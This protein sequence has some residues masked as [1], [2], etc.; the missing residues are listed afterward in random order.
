VNNHLT[1]F[2][3]EGYD[4]SKVNDAQLADDWRLTCAKYATMVD[5]GKTEFETIDACRQFA[6]RVLEEILK[7]G[8]ITFHPEQMK[9]TSLDLLRHSLGKLIKGGLYLVPPHGELFYTG[10]KT[11]M[12][13]SRNFKRCLDFNILCSND[14]AYGFI[15][16]KPPRQIEEFALLPPRHAITDD[17]RKEWWPKVSKLWYYEPR[18]F[19]L[20]QE[21]K[22]ISLPRGIQ[23][24]I[25]E[26]QFP[27]PAEEAPLDVLQQVDLPE[28]DK[29]LSWLTSHARELPDFVWIPDFVSI[30]GS[31]LF[32]DRPP[33]DLDV[34]ARVD[35]MDSLLG[36]KLDRVFREYFD[37][38][39]H[40]VLE[41]A[42][43]NWPYL[44][45]YDLVLRKK[46]KF[47]VT[48][49]EEPEFARRIYHQRAA[50]EEVKRQA[51][52]TREEDK[53]MLFRFYLGIKPTRITLAGERQTVDRFV[54]YFL[55]DDFPVFN[56]KKYDGLRLLIFKDKDKVEL[57]SEDGSE[58]THNMPGVVKELKALETESFIIEAE[59]EQWLDDIHQPRES[60]AAKMHTKEI[61]P[62][63]DLIANVFTCLYLNGADLHQET[64]S[65]RQEALD[66]LGIQYSTND[67]PDLSHNLNKVP[68][69]ICHNQKELKQSTER[70]R[71][72]PASEGV[73][74]KKSNSIYYLDGN[75]REGWIKFHNNAV[76]RGKVIEALETKTSG[77]W[78]YRYG[79]LPGSL[80][81]R[82]GDLAEV[83]DQELVEV[84]K[85]FSTNIECQRGDLIEVEFETFNL[86]HDQ[87]TDRYEVSAWAPVFLRRLDSRGKPDG[88]DAVA[89]KAAAEHILQEKEIS[90]E[91]EVIYLG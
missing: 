4:P 83:G 52:A 5:G 1:M 6:L 46:S 32:A 45:L 15:R 65:I 81:F 86:T 33:H 30:T 24:F 39:P 16:F 91:G 25:D 48:A 71:F 78:N 74:A 22:I 76:L 21:P 77:V 38:S 56:S 64:E 82:K 59:L 13:K 12:V 19:I 61:E 85:T 69:D 67:I 3:L 60:V 18:D 44:P 9:D 10:K 50:S 26:V 11:A 57:W 89:A 20:Y 87:R 47:E 14:L 40:L 29:R 90:A 68:N 72:L 66:S 42:G 75:A 53:L 49:I 31:T 54:S 41:P 73:V 2:Q 8:K 43:P 17:E 79:I 84:G 70:L 35:K 58:L 62:D 27:T 80:E 34:V 63:D 23:V 28:K 37:R 55:E 7:R 88:V 51:Q 36:L